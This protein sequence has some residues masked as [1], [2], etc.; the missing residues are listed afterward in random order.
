MSQYAVDLGEA[1]APFKLSESDVSPRV[2]E[3]WS[4]HVAKLVGVPNLYGDNS[5][6]AKQNFTHDGYSLDEC[7][8]WFQSGMHAGVA[9]DR[10]IETIQAAYAELDAMS[11]S[12]IGSLYA[13]A[14]RSPEEF[15]TLAARLETILNAQ[16]AEACRPER[17]Y[18]A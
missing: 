3:D 7:F 9:V 1:L 11:P 14:E 16:A 2:W 15:A 18:V 13:A 17:F 5:T 6:A 12:Q 8:G 4:A 10:I